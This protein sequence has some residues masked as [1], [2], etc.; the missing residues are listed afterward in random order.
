MRRREAGKKKPQRR[1]LLL[2]Q[3]SA[4]EPGCVFP[5]RLAGKAFDIGLCKLLFAPFICSSVSTCWDPV[6]GLVSLTL[7]LALYL[8]AEA[9]LEFILAYR[10]RPLPGSGWLFFDGI[11]HPCSRHDDLRTWPE[12]T[13][14]AIGIL[15]GISMVF[16]G[17]S[18]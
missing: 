15:V 12:S 14:W 18:C 7:G 11:Y 13:A 10:L 2:R 1:K 6:A 4:I 5:T 16:R 9:T 8:A 17:I 3:G